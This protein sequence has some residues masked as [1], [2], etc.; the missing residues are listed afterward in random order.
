MSQ[1][2]FQKL[3]EYISGAQ[4]VLIM[5]DERI[6]GDTLGSSLGLFHT[7]RA[8]GKTSTIFSPK[9]LPGTFSFLPGNEHIVRDRAVVQDATI[10]LIIVCDNSDGVYLP[11]LLSQRIRHVPLVCIDHH[12]TNPHYGTLNLIEEH[13]PS[14]AD[15]V[16]R[17]LKYAG[18]R[19]PLSAAQCLLTGMCTDTLLFSTQ[20]TTGYVMRLASELLVQGAD[21]APILQNTLFNKS[22]SAIKLRGIALERLTYDSQ[23]EAWYTGITEKDLVDTKAEEDDIKSL[24]EYLNEVLDPSHETV[25]VYYEKPNGSLKGSA[26]SRSRNIAKIVEE[27]FGG[28]GHPLAAGFVLPHTRFQQHHDGVWRPTEQNANIS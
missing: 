8:S 16:Y 27:R 2:V 18:Y 13:A 11:P 9:P 26:R 23:L 19:I 22:L 14:T 28:G 7:L 5:T 17:F 25:I 10:D 20:H 24:S 4:H 3:R 6:D 21:L 12:A 15:I 1:E